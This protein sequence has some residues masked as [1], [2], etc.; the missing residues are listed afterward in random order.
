MNYEVVVVGGGI[1]GLAT[2]ALLAARGVSVCLLE[3]NSYVGGCVG[4][5]EH[6]GY[7]FEPTFGLYRGFHPGEVFDGL[8]AETRGALPS[9]YEL[10]PAYSVRLPDGVEIAVSSNIAEFEAS[11]SAAFPECVASAADFYRTLTAGSAH[12]QKQ[13]LASSLK[14][15]SIRFRS[16]IDAQLQM[17]GQSSSDECPLNAAAD[18][19]DPRRTFWSIHGGAQRL[20]DSLVEA[21][22]RNGGALRLNAAVLRFAYGSDGSP[23]GVDLLTGEQVIAS[24]AIVSNLTSWDTYGKL[25]GLSRTPRD[26]AM[27]LKRTQS[28]GAYLLLLAMERH[29]AEQLFS[30]RVLALTELKND[31][32]PD[33]LARQFFFSLASSIASADR[34]P[35]TV[36]TLTSAEDWFSFHDDHTA[37]EEQDQRMLEIVWSRLHSAMPELGDTVELIETVTP[38]TYYETTRRKF[39]M[40]GSSRGMTAE[41]QSTPMT[42]FPNVFIVSDTTSAGFGIEAVAKSAFLVANLITN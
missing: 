34:A 2:A 8:F 38:Q 21:F 19:L 10:S 14:E 5:I 28:A 30:P 24:K 37:H 22:K 36:T 42:P 6:L 11:L 20:A 31:E 16:F 7:E 39:G 32:Q 33:P 26:I 41:Q 40:I 18:I 4:S 29:A 15:C 13:P 27:R 23:T 1:G 9:V 3:R 25:I 17:F 12:D 35:V